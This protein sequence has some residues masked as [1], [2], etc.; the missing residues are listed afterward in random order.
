MV[1]KSTGPQGK[2][3]TDAHHEGRRA[4]RL[5][6]DLPTPEPSPDGRFVSP[7]MAGFGP[8]AAG[9][10]VRDFV[11]VWDYACGGRFRGF[12]AETG[13]GERALFVFFDREV[14]GKDLKPG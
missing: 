5:P 14:V 7:A 9:V 13:Y 10:W 6:H 8:A 2:L 12:V 4:V 1:G 3:V 11:E